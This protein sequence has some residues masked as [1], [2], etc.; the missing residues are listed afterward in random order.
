[1]T[2]NH[3]FS[4]FSQTYLGF[5]FGVE[6]APILNIRNNNADISNGQ[7]VNKC[8][9]EVMLPFTLQAPNSHL[10]TLNNY[11]INMDAICL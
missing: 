2:K 6:F 11:D 3:D 1:M 4:F 7:D 10:I 9:E 5:K 8:L